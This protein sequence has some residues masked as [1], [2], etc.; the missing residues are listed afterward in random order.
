MKVNGHHSIRAKEKGNIFKPKAYWLV[1][2][3]LEVISLVARVFY[4]SFWDVWYINCMLF[5]SYLIS[6]GSLV[7]FHCSYATL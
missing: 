5:H 3:S 7:L 1:Q 2:W 4:M 6:S